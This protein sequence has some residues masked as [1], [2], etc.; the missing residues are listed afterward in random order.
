MNILLVTQ[1]FE[2]RGGSDVMVHQTKRLLEAQGHRVHIFAA[3][4]SDAPDDGVF[5]SA[6]HFDNPRPATLWKFLFS[7]EARARLETFLD[8]NPI[9]A[10]HLHIHYGALTSSILKPLKKRGIRVVQHLHEYRSFCSVYT[11]E[12]DGNTCLDCSV[13]NY[14]AGLKHRCNRGSLLRSA[15]STAEMYMA[16]RLGAKSVPDVFLTVSDFQR[17]MIVG[18]GLPARKTHTL[19]NPVDPMFFAGD[20]VPLQERHGVLYVGRIEDYKGVYDLLDVAERLRDIPFTVIGHGNGFDKLNERIARQG[21]SNVTVLGK[22]PREDILAHLRRH[23][24]MLVPSRWNETFGLTAVE[25]MAAGLPVVVTRMGGLPEVVEDGVSG[26]VVEM[27]DVDAMVEHV[28]QLHADNEMFERVSL[29]AGTRVKNIFSE[30]KYISSLM[31]F[32]GATC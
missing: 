7:P 20:P 12:R 27:G 30:Q 17:D 8:A 10:A 5:P 24:V 4:A 14:K 32:L 26:F 15:L 19:Y 13:G 3:R 22:L 16:D 11:A 9:D 31:G 2:I 6:D 21:A 18:Q 29:E 28:R 1:H 25:A 23:R